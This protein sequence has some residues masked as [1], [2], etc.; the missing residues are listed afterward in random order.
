MIRCWLGSIWFG[1]IRLDVIRLYSICF[2][3]IRFKSSLFV[4][5]R[6]SESIRFDP[7]YIW[8]A[9]IRVGVQLTRCCLI[10]GLIRFELFRFELSVF[11]S[12]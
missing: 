2:D 7:I 10:V 12:I 9:S 5:L 8:F 1:L 11:D 4:D 3:L 6:L